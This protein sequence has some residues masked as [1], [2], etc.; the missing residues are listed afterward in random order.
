MTEKMLP[1][2]STFMGVDLNDGS[3]AEQL[4]AKVH[5]GVGAPHLQD[6]SK[7]LKE[8]GAPKKFS[9]S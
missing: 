9:R 1:D 2:V 5:H 4:A 8:L 3:L 6:F 7:N